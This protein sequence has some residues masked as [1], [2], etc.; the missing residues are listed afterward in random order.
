[1][2]NLW[3]NRV[4]IKGAI[5]PK[6]CIVGA[7][8]AGFYAAQHL[9][10]KLEKSEIDIL[11]KLPVPFGLVRFGVAP[12]HPEVKNVI[13]TFTKTA[14]HPNVKYYGN[15]SFGKDVFLQDLQRFYHVVL[16]T[17]GAEEY[18]KLNIPGEEFHNV[19]PARKIVGW[20]NGVPTDKD[21]NLNL[22]GERM[23]IFGQGNVAIDVARILLSP[24]DQLKKTDITEYALE[25]ISQSKVKK[26]YL[27]GRRGPLQAAYTIKELREMLKLK[28]CQTIW[29]NE[30]FSALTSEIL[31]TLARPKKRITELMISSLQQETKLQPELNFFSPIFFRS[32]LEILGEQ[33]AEKVIL[34]VNR[35]VGNDILTQK[36]QLT[37]KTEDLECDSIVTSIGYKGVQV[38]P[39]VPFDNQQ[40]IVKNTDGKISTG[41]YTTGWLG[42]GPVGV[43]LTTMSNA[44]SV[45]ERIVKDINVDNLLESNKKGYGGVQEIVNKNN[46]PVV[47]WQD[48]EKIDKHEVDKGKIIGKPREKLVTIKDMLEVAN[49]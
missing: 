37:D 20:Y 3:F 19:I 29:R 4:H 45:A 14:Q 46:I 8:P 22:D 41:L 49:S 24:I 43:I 6:I 25:K 40:G 42:T 16:L 17:Y 31:G 27:V 5:K 2:Y 44:F 10:K 1:M 48:W 36:A 18:R 21:L 23:I 9:S 28:G 38:D 39:S 33:K 47:N 7:G 15:I 13:N 35:L 32:P 34:G 12:D 26:I 11:E 30:D